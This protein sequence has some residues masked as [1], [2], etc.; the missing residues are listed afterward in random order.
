MRRNLK[1]H[2]QPEP[3]QQVK[4]VV[5]LEMENLVV[6]HFQMVIVVLII[7]IVVLKDILVI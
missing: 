5:Q 4:H 3:V 1:I 7:F 6:V 2:A